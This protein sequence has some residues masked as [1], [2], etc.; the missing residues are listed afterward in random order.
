LLRRSGNWHHTSVGA[1][2]TRIL[3]DLPKLSDAIAVSYFEHSSIS[4]TGP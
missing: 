3:R 2:V 1:I 4:R